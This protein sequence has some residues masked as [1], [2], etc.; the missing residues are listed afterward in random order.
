MTE[1]TNTPSS[2]R[3]K[4][5]KASTHSTHEALDKRIME[6]GIFASRVHYANFLR[7]QYRFHREID[8]LYPRADLAALLPDMEGRRR[9]GLVAQDLCDLGEAAPSPA[10]LA[11]LASHPAPSMA[12]MPL[13]QALGW[14][15]VAEGS[16]LG[17]AVLYKLAAPLGLGREFGARHLAAPADGVA[18]HW[19]EFVAALDAL[20]LSSAQEDE[21]VAGAKAA[22]LAVRGYVEEELPRT[23]KD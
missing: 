1:T 6:A 19:R 2:S 5:L 7:V 12:A 22:F 18:Q 17:G 14:L 11:P 10:S 16:N 8:A 9:F 4:R 23:P 15:Y 21:V 3:A 20:P 13:P